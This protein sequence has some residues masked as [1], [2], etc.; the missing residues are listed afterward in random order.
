LAI[1]TTA[2]YFVVVFVFPPLI[3]RLPDSPHAPSALT[4]TYEDGRGVL[5]KV[6]ATC[7]G[8]NFKVAD[9]DLDRPAAGHDDRAVVVALEVHGKG[10]VVQLAGELGDLEGVLGV[11][12]G[13]VDEVFA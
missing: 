2:A 12:A 4:E 10:S 6:L 13:E 8:R 7:T 5:R 11:T 1:A 3:R 9:V